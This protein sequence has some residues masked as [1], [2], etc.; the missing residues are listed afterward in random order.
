MNDII[1]K[2][3]INNK[4][5]FDKNKILN[6]LIK[7]EKAYMIYGNIV[8]KNLPFKFKYLEDWQL[9]KSKKLLEE[10]NILEY[11]LCKKN[12]NKIVPNYKKFKRGTL[13]RVDFGVGLGSEMSQVHFA[14]V[15]NKYDNIKNNILTVVPLTSQEG[16]FNLDLGSLVIDELI[17][18]IASEKI[19][20]FS[21]D[22][23]E[24]IDSVKLNK[25]KVLENYYSSKVKR[26][27]ACCCL[28]T[29]ISKTRIFKPI[30]EYDIIGKS[31]C[32]NEV[33]NKIDEDNID[34]F[35]FKKV[36]SHG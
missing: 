1:K 36:D 2:K 33:M 35:I 18:K 32:S 4:K 22:E 11:N 14:I 5:E 3:V 10:A 30:N 16:K 19:S 26:T 28:V 31:I 21:S 29:T 24:I 20:C 34:K 27:Y 23:K 6:N 25:L 7:I 17:K 13:I 15:L 8:Q 9:I 12:T